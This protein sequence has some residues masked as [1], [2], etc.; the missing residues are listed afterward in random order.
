MA[1]RSNGFSKSDQRDA[2]QTCAQSYREHMAEF[3]SMPTLD[4][5]YA[6]IDVNKVMSSLH[7]KA[8]QARLRK[9]IA[10][11]TAREVAEHASPS[12][13]QKLGGEYVIKDDP[14]LIYHHQVMNLAESRENI[15]EAFARYRETLPDDRKVL[16]D[17]YHLVDIALKVVGVGSVGTFS[18]IALLMASNDDPLFL[19]IKQAGPSVLEPYI[20]KSIYAHH[21]QR[22]V[23]GQRLMQSASDIFLGWTYGNKGRHFYVRQLRDVQDKSSRRGFQPD[24]NA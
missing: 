23:T 18:A 11:E 5:W 24:D 9:R 3:A 6:D 19:Q 20:G 1:C 22:V 7:D 21:G 14:P 8:T 10:K 17:R 16:L 13:T 4:V 2:A 15:S 12:M